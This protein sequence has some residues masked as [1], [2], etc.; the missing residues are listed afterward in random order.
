MDGTFTKLRP[1]QAVSLIQA[2]RIDIVVTDIDLGGS[3]TG[4]D[5]DEAYRVAHPQV[6]VVYTSGNAVVESRMVS[7]SMF[8]RKP[9]DTGEVLA[10]C[11]WLMAR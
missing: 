4:W 1:A 5:V 9:Y 3:L 10:A 7:N 11:D 2:I 6:A 8:F